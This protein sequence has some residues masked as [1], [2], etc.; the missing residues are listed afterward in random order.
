[1]RLMFTATPLAGQDMTDKPKPSNQLATTKISYDG[2]TRDFKVDM[3][4]VR[5]S[6]F[7]RQ[8][9]K[10]DIQEAFNAAHDARYMAP[11][12]HRRSLR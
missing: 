6:P 10:S 7:C 4:S 5:Q 1:M 11:K 8:L 9:K 2:G 12:G 3:K